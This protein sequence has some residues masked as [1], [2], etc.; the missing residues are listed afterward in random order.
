L[1]PDEHSP[2]KLGAAGY[3]GNKA[4]SEKLLMS[5]SKGAAGI[6]RPVAIAGPRDTSFSL[7]YWLSKMGNAAEIVAPGDGS[8][9]VQIVDVRDV[10]DWIVN[11][12]EHSRRGIYN[13]G[14]HP[15]SFRRFIDACRTAVGGRAQAIWVGREFLTEQEGVKYENLPYWNPDIPGLETASTAKVERAGWSGRPFVETARAAWKSYQ[16]MIPV[17]V[18]YPINQYGSEIGL[19][20][21]RERQ[22]ID[23]WE[24]T[25]AARP[26][27]DSYW[28]LQRPA[29]RSLTTVY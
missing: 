25:G 27:L 5:L 29:R 17:A 3:G 16:N 26:T 4:R 13:T 9:P 8:D 19:S 14:A 2:T 20:S 10:G 22:I 11:C 6:I 12:V 1:R 15:V 18:T 23:R 24:R 28:S 7:H 21:V